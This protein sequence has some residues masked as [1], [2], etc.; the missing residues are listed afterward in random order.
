V[1]YEDSLD[2]ALERA[3]ADG[4]VAGPLGESCKE[5]LA[6]SKQF[7]DWFLRV[8]KVF[9]DEERLLRVLDIHGDAYEAAKAAWRCHQASEDDETASALIGELSRLRLAMS[10]LVAEQPGEVPR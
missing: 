9:Y 6:A 10:S 7:N 5:V 3:I 8:A 2:Y 1:G 4:Q